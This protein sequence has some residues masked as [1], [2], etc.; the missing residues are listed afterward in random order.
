MHTPAHA[1]ANVTVLIAGL[2]TRCRDAASCRYGVMDP[3]TRDWNDGVL[4][5]IFR[6]VNGP[7]TA[8]KETEV[9]WIIFDGDVDALWVE[10][11]NSVMDDN[12][13]LTL[14]NGERIRLQ[15][16]CKLVVEVFDLQYASPATVSRCGMVWVDPKNL[17]YRPFYENWVKTRRKGAAPEWESEALLEFFD[18]YVDKAVAYVLDGILDGQEVGALQTVIPMANISMVQQLAN[19]VDAF[20]TPGGEEDRNDL[21]SI[22]YFCLAWSVGAALLGPERTKFDAFLQ[23]QA[24]CRVPTGSV[25]E[26]FYSMV[27]RQWFTW[28]SVVPEYLEPSPFVYHEISVP[29]VDSV[30]YDQ[31][32]KTIVPNG[33]PVLYVGDS[34]TA[35]TVTIQNYLDSLDSEKSNLLNINFSSRTSS[36]DVQHNI[37]ANVDKRTGRIYGPTAGKNLVIFIDDMNMPKVDSYGTQQPVALLHL[38][39]GRGVMYDRGKDLEMH[40]LKVRRATAVRGFTCCCGPVWRFTSKG[41]PSLSCQCSTR[42]RT[43]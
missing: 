34:G 37:E 23:Q 6:E 30:L 40:I 17:G 43:A 21:E 18:N 3:E 1:I 20:W 16:H 35:K 11:M 27:D 2:L 12:R 7:L 41:R 14:P 19:S 42:E 26:S 5:R 39:V 9:R 28:E 36:M 24:E 4:S 15:V 10:N 33:T 31:I 32:L 25:Y 8:G 29:T 13:L 22:F 38:L